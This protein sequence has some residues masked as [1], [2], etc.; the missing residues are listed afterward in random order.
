MKGREADLSTTNSNG[1]L[2]PYQLSCVI[3]AWKLKFW[4]EVSEFFLTT[5]LVKTACNKSMSEVDLL[6]RT[7]ADRNAH[8]DFSIF[9]IWLN[10]IHLL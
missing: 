10:K 9:N 5:Y 7:Q 8:T 1:G 3:C 4:F 2:S 6:Y